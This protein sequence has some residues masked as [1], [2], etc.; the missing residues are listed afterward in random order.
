MAEIENAV[1]TGLRKE[2]VIGSFA[3]GRRAGTYW[4]IRG[5]VADYGLG[6]ALSCPP[7]RTA[8]LASVPTGLEALPA[9]LQERLVNWGYA[10]CDT[11]LRRHVDPALPPGSFPYAGGV[12]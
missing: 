4:G 1:V 9:R 7:E 6:D 10:I 8:E 12:A 2:Q 11:A 5:H 3:S